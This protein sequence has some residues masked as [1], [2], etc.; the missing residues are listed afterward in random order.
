MP[1]IYLKLNKLGRSSGRPASP[2]Y[3]K[4]LYHRT[5]GEN[6][7]VEGPEEEQALGPDWGDAQPDVR[8]SRRKDT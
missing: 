6:Q 3:P 4:R 1:T 7:D 2:D 8:F 5:T